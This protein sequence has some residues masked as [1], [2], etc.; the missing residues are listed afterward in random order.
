M[1]MKKIFA[2]IICI[3][4]LTTLCAGCQ[5]KEIEEIFLRPEYITIK[6]GETAELEYTYLPSDASTDGITYTSTNPEVAAVD[7]TG[8]VTG[9]SSGTA[10]IMVTAASGVVSSCEVTVE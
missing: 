3:V 8:V 9:I 5:K 7:P 1:A 4:L 10:H 2:L 6:V